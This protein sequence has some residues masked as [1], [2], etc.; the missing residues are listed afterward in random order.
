MQTQISF[1]DILFKVEKA[2]DYKA[3]LDQLVLD[4]EFLIISV[5]QGVALAALSTTA[6]AVFVEAKFEYIPYIVSGFLFILIFWSGAIIHA[7]SFIN[8]PLDI[9]HNFLYFLASLVEVVAFSEVTNP[10]NWFLAVL[11]FFTVAAAL[12][13]YDSRLI[14]KRAKDFE[15]SREKQKLY[16]HIIARHL[17][18]MK[19]LV[20]AGILFNLISASLILIFPSL[21]LTKH[22]HI[23]L[24]SSQAIFSLGLLINSTKGFTQRIDLISQAFINK[25]SQ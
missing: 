14:K 10:R 6:A 22:W 11:A 15:Q 23:L 18:E 24:S 5:V 19:I 8:W 12:Y 3:R 1:S 25:R 9:A 2:N 13:F 16:K 4:I 7:V 20:P 17:F 21:F